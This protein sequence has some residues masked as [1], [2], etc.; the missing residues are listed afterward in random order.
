MEGDVGAHSFF[1]DSGERR[2]FCPALGAGV[3]R[4]TVLQALRLQLVPVLAR[5]SRVRLAVGSVPSLASV[6]SVAPVLRRDHRDRASVDR[7]AVDK[8][9]GRYAYVG[10]ERNRPDLFRR[11]RSLDVMQLPGVATAGRSVDRFRPGVWRRRR[12]S[13]L[14]SS[15]RTDD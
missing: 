2:R 5:L 12:S 15:G 6:G 13:A 7:I 11:L 1:A 3:D 4:S 14:S 10:C 9:R 8:S